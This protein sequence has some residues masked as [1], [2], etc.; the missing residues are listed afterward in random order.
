VD[1]MEEKLEQMEK[2]MDEK[3]DQWSK[4]WTNCWF[5]NLS[6][7]LGPGV[8][9]VGDKLH[10]P[11]QEVSVYLFDSDYALFL[12]LLWGIQSLWYLSHAFFFDK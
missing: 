9:G 10:L 11:P 2:K 1:R 12:L 6:L 5:N 7:I 3:F 4:K 8:M